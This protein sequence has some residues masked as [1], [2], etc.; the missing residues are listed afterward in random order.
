MCSLNCHG[1]LGC[2]RVLVKDKIKLPS[3]TEIIAFGKI[4]TQ[5]IL[6]DNLCLVE[7]EE[8]FFK[9]EKA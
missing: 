2:F 7:P 5:N 3:R 6:K 1:T 4:E 9:K 8:K